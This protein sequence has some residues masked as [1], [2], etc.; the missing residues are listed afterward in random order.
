[1]THQEIIESFITDFP[2]CEYIFMDTKDLIFSPKV[3]FICETECKRYGHSW[4]C[5]P[6]IGT[7]EECMER[8]HQFE[9]VL[10]FT[11]V[12]DVPD[13]FDM[14]GCLDARRDHEQVSYELSERM[15]ED[16]GDVLTLTTGCMI[17]EECGYPDT[18]CRHPKQRFATIESHGI[19]IMKTADDAGISYN[20]GSNMVTYFTL[21]LY[22]DA[23]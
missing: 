23:K 14:Q 12:T 4:A 2:V 7:I 13:S 15:K 16:F 9:H 19:L 10:L 22:N 21:I 1:M 11:T 20:C 17:C 18:P 5:P 3:R 8:C 6:V